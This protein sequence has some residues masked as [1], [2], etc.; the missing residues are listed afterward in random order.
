MISRRDERWAGQKPPASYTLSSPPQDR[1]FD[2]PNPSVNSTRQPLILT[3]LMEAGAQAAASD[4]P[5]RTVDEAV[6]SFERMVLGF[7]EPR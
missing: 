4:D 2:A 7:A 3:A 5:T 1:V 6:S